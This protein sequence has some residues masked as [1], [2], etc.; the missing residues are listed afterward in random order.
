[1]MS[2]LMVRS[3]KRT[4]LFGGGGVVLVMMFLFQT[5][6]FFDKLVFGLSGVQLMAEFHITPQQFG[7]I[8]SSFFLLFSLSGVLVGLF[9]IG[10][11]STK[12]IMVIMAA[13]WSA[14]QLPIVFTGSI[15]IIVVC[16]VMLGFG[17]GP[18]LPTALHACYNWFPKE[19]RSLPSAVVL[20]GIS[21][22]FLIGGPFLSYVIINYGWRS[23]FLTC[24]ALGLIW[25]IVWA[26]VGREGPYAAGPAAI[27]T[28]LEP[29][30]PSRMLWLDPTV[31]GITIMSFMSYYV[32]GMSAIWL[33]PYLQAG[34]GY[35][36][37]AVGWV[38]SLVFAFQ[39]PLLLCGSW[40]SQI[41][42]RRGFSG[43]ASLGHAS[44]I[45]LAVAGG[46]LIGAVYTHGW[47]QI[48]LI[49]IAFAT[50]SLTTIY[51]PVALGNMAPAAQRGKL[52]VAIYS[53]NALAGLVS[54]YLTGWVIGLGRDQ[55]TGYANAMI[56]AAAMLLVGALSS[57]VLMFPDRSAE[58][59]ARAAAVPFPKTVKVSS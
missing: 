3:D 26:V 1:M 31:V 30:V 57:L 38:I 2:G 20:Q 28:R 29:T 9:V 27:A 5:L 36:R 59:F 53:G 7:L 46:A 33:P 37:A 52:L 19:K 10:R 42:L 47:L 23:G 14:S 17:E 22:G 8:G 13:V 40:I 55:P 51:G 6:N 35:D 12:W 34:L 44:T 39:S 49:A 54:T 21:A 56:L 18:G 48:A 11:V 50:P 43:R 15:G 32:V 25:L 58:R 41:M 45:A 4:P 24:A 16:R